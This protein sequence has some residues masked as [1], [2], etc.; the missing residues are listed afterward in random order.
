[1]S[2]QEEIER[3]ITAL[4]QRAAAAVALRAAM[5]VFPVFAMRG[6]GS[7]AAFGYWPEPERAR[8]A[9]AI[10][11]CYQILIFGNNLPKI[12]AAAAIAA[13]PA[14]ATYAAAADAAYAARAAAYAPAAA[15]AARAAATAARAA[16][17]AAAYATATAALEDIQLAE[18]SDD[19]VPM[20]TMPLW[21][22]TPGDIQSLWRDLQKDL[23]S[24][25]AGFDVWIKWYQDRLDGKPLDLALEEKWA[26]L[27]DEVL[28]REPAAINAYLAKLR[29]EHY[30]TPKPDDPDEA[31]AEIPESQEPG[32]Q[33]A[34]GED[35]KIDLKPSGLAPPDDLAEIAAMRGVLTKAADT[36][37]GMT[38]G[39]NELSWIAGI[40]TDYRT[41][42]AA[43]P[44]P[45]DEIYCYGQWLENAHASMKA[46]IESNNK[47]YPD[48]APNAAA[49]INTMLAIHGP[50][51]AST[52]RGQVLMK[53]ARD[54]AE[55]QA[56]VEAFKDKGR[57][58]AA[59]VHGAPE[60]V[61][62]PAREALERANE[63]I[64]EGPHPDRATE[65]ARTADSNFLIAAA[66]ALIPE[67]EVG[68][69]EGVRTTVKLAVTGTA[70][71]AT[72][73]AYSAAPGALAAL[74]TFFIVN[75]PLL[76]EF[77]AVAGFEIRWLPAFLDW[78]EVQRSKRFNSD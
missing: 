50:M 43:D 13:A 39:S 49:A 71:A 37:I 75:M 58:F 61:A 54:F 76:R 27:P 33:F 60:A 55:K 42:I 12:K 4:P 8:H 5:R 73:T 34:P 70:M 69:R 51:I 16:A 68:L 3:L 10:L 45:I 17:P 52:K 72:L 23:R 19:L 66:K 9:F 63:A 20:L 31:L 64:G 56:D 29:D 46:K 2:D 1:M 36:L 24:L 7:T 41:A 74:E 57:Q 35:G 38:A 28:K 53:R 22:K 65:I 78:L 67:I 47:D 40:A 25:D 21:P 26:L 30:R 14:D 48:L 77:A 59:A 44:P 11:R 18:R 62:K 15:Y 32:L 6:V